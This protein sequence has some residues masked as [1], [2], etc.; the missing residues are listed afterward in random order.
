MGRSMELLPRQNGV[1]KFAYYLKS[2]DYDDTRIS[3]K[4]ILDYRG[5]ETKGLS[6]APFLNSLDDHPN[7]YY[8]C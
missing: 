6:H 8:K 1:K 2:H 7:F 5:G 3:R 4:L